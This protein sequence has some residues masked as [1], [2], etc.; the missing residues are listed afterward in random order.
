LQSDNKGLVT[1]K[2]ELDFVQSFRYTME[3]RFANKLTFDIEVNPV[4]LNCKLPVLS[5]LPLI[6]NIVVHNMIDSEY[7]MTVTIRMNENMELVVSN[8]IYPKL[9]P[10]ETN[11]T[12][13]KNLKNRFQLLMNKQIRIE[14]NGN[15]FCVYLP[16]MSMYDEGIDC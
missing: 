2:E 14:D 3:V 9:L 10:P 11:G 1:L 13:L 15:M 16:L 5:I 8:P 4:I 12:G 6:D 7:K